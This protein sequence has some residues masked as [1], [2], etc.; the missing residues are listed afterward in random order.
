VQRPTQAFRDEHRQLIEQIEHIREAARELPRLP[1]TERREVVGRVL[2]FLQE[3]LLP[4][5][6]AEEG[7]LYTEWSR[8]VGYPDAAEPMIHDHR[9][10]RARIARLADVELSDTEEIQELLYGLHALITVHFDKEEAIPLHALDQQP[11]EVA[12]HILERMEAGAH[13]AHAR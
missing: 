13:A 3:T 9:A 6:E 7:V 2:R 8:Q 1:W 11:P 5:A 4:H 10:I 12:E